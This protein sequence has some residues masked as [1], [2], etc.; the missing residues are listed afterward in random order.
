MV[1]E[2]HEG[3]FGETRPFKVFSPG[4]RISHYR[5]IEKMG[6]G[7]MGVVYKAEDTKLKRHVALKFL[8]PHLTQNAEAKNRFVHEARSAS[9]L[10]HSN[11]CTVH[12][13]DETEDGQMFISMACYEGETL[14]KKL[15]G[16]HLSVDDA[17]DIA[18][19]VA[20]GLRE[21]HKKGII[22]R[23]IKPANLIITPLGQV[24]I[25]DFGLAKL[26][27][28]TRI[29]RA[30][31]AMGTVAYMSPEQASGKDVDRRSDVWALG[32]VLYEMLAGR[33]PFKGDYEQ[34]MV[35]SIL[36]EDPDQLSKIRPGVP[37]DLESI[38][39]KA[40]QKSP[41][42]RYQSSEALLA[43]L[44][45]LRSGA[46]VA[47]TLPKR[48]SLKR[49][50]LVVSAAAAVLVTAIVL[51]PRLT[52]WLT[53]ARA[54]AMTLAVI[55]FE[56]IGGEEAGHL[57]VGLAEGICVKLSKVAGIQ[58]VSS[59]DIRR[60]RKDEL[61]AKEIALRLRAD[62]A[63][64][65]SMLKSGEKIRVTPQLIE[66]STGNVVWTEPFDREFDDVFTFMDEVSLKIVDALKIRFTQEDRLAL[67]ERPTDSPQ[68]YD[69]YL[70]GRH[71]YH[72]E[73]VADNELAA[74]E[75][76]KAL[77]IDPDYPL[78]LA[79]LADAYVQRYRERYDY[80]E[81]WLDQA[82]SLIDRAL[83]FEPGLAEAYKSRAAVLLEKENLLAALEAAE[84]ARDLRQDWDEPYVQL[85]VIYKE[86]G[87]ARLALRMY[88]QALKIRPSVAAWCGKGE[89]L[90]ARGE[91]DSAMTAFHAALS[92]SPHN[93]YPYYE[94]GTHYVKLG[95]VA[96]ADSMLRLAMKVRPD[97]APSRVDLSWL[98]YDQGRVQ[99]AHDLVR[100]FIDEYP[101]NCH[102]YN[103]LFEIV[104]W[105]IGDYEAAIAVVDEAVARNPDRVWPYLLLASSHAWE[106]S[107]SASPDKA[108]A[109]LEKAL[110]L[111]PRSSRV[112]G[113]AAEIHADI[114][115]IDKALEYFAQALELNPGGVTILNDMA[116]ELHSAGR[117]HEAAAAALRAL[118]Q[119][120]GV[121]HKYENDSYK[122][123]GR[124]MPLLGRTDEYY[125]IL[126]SAAQKYGPDNPRFYI[127]LGM[128]QCKRGE[129]LEAISTFERALEINEDEDAIM[130]LAGAQWLSGDTDAAMSSYK[131]QKAA[132][133]RGLEGRVITLLTYLGR[134][135]EVEE[136][137]EAIRASGNLDLW[138]W[139]AAGWYSSMRR[140][141]D[142]IA[143]GREMCQSA[144]VTW[145]ND[146][147]W[148]TVSW[149]RENGDLAQALE[150]IEEAKSV[151]PL[152]YHPS[153]HHEQALI[154][155]IRGH[156]ERAE[157][158]AQSALE[159]TT[160]DHGQD[161][162]LTLLARLHFAAGRTDEALRTLGAV[163][164]V[165]ASHRLRPFYTLAQIKKASGSLDAGDATERALFLAT[166]AARSPTAWG[167]DLAHARG[168]CAL[169]AA[170]LGDSQRAKEEVAYA[171]RLEPERAD[172]AY[173]AACTHSL[174]GETDLA[175][176]WLQTA[177]ERG[178]QELWW[179][180]VDPDLDPL[181]NLPRFGQIMADWDSHLQALD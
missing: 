89:I 17:L 111:R 165:R 112:L 48:K 35:Y 78:A 160:P 149:Q 5:I 45:R 83:G 1:S 144:E 145:K 123:L 56:D 91:V 19:Q 140:F 88:E 141:D 162:H 138:F 31:T 7:G 170:R 70:K 23:D 174:I 40:L 124:V 142:A 133:F 95:R 9:A 30:G 59:D 58:V 34:A 42:D 75:F 108:L 167:V 168:Y 18:E 180:R 66:A 100:S 153:L 63:V 156:L 159:G 164:G 147:L 43:D 26:A 54:T 150:L 24:K 11:I 33:L 51:W 115:D 25:M 38:I 52:R 41:E 116:W 139:A 29:T 32:V 93:E 104:A 157:E 60:L 120:P 179:A 172:V 143:L 132:Q 76:Q 80:D 28:Q 4:T 84:K 151:L 57:A 50:L 27:G 2:L 103:Q 119:A 13:I 161:P 68:A 99:E 73:T 64:G 86:R 128:E 135:D 126:R 46:R 122:M 175:I 39:T 102:A 47:V 118:E 49:R 16:G 21:A 110:E 166:R 22:H 130:G 136:Q 15:E 163:K 121:A 152:P 127:K 96:E 94:I 90:F 146:I 81:Y 92:H 62:Y 158:Y 129:F 176:A 114:G 113:W 67:R 79:G 169:A 74:K 131:R 61:A 53:P 87:E 69:H 3:D 71:H 137:L 55:D 105:G 77:R 8:P 72:R 97:H 65:G 37:D 177:V 85:G 10:D 173:A 117:H 82:D 12:E 134:F 181:R 178:H 6:A 106:M 44:Q 125:Q 171:L 36:N 101:Y 98:L 109:A 155:A 154:A 148:N 14:R 107:E 20:E